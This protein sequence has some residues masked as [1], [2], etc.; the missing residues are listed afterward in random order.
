MSRAFFDLD[1]AIKDGYQPPP[2]GFVGYRG[3]GSEGLSYSLDQESAADLKEAFTAARDVHP[4]EPYFTSPPGSV[5]FPANPWPVE[6]P[7]MRAVW[8][9]LY[10]AMDRVATHLMRIFALALDL[11]PAFFDDKVDRNISCLRA[12]NYPQQHTPPLPNQLRAGAHTD[13][14]SL[15]LLSM[16]DAPGGLEVHRG[17]GVWEPVRVPSGVLVTN[18]GDLMAQWTNDIWLSSLHRVGNPPPGSA[19]SRRQSLAFFHQPNYDAEVMPLPSCCGPELPPKYEPT[20]SGQHL[21][22]K[23][24]KAKNRNV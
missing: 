19:G 20:T 8:V 12:L 3:V 23:L 6:V 17:D 4:D 14:G 15:T 21:F 7:Q 18:I 10:D 24:T 22:M 16:D 9:A 5:F 2:G 11:P 13:Y 1:I